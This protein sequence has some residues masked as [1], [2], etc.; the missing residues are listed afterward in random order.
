MPKSKPILKAKL[1]VP[2]YN[3]FVWLIVSK[4]V[5]QE[6]IK[7]NHLFGTPPEQED[8]D[9]LCA[10][11]GGADFGLFFYPDKL[12]VLVIAHEVFHLT[13]RIMEWANMNFDKDH[14]EQGALL[15]G[16]LMDE[17]CNR[18]LKVKQ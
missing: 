4:N 18:I 9:A 16:F 8:Y 2:I 3:A 15:H 17:V 5:H 12:S 13:H 11:S 6:R 10:R 7:F 14:H 1:K